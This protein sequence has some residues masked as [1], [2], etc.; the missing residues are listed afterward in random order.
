MNTPEIAH[1]LVGLCQKGQFAE[2][3][4]K[5]YSPDVVSVEP[6][7]DS[8]ESQGLE[9]VKAKGDWWVANNIVHQMTVEGPYLGGDKFVVRFICDITFK[10]TGQRRLLDELG[11]YTVRGGRVVHEQFFYHAG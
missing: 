1:G 11:I 6:T 8:R 9:A 4:E 3:V 5:Y 2:A 10:P 7:G